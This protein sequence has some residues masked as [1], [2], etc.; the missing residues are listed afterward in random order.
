MFN[1]VLSIFERE[2]I[3]DALNLTW[4]GMLSIFLGIAL[5]F[6]AIFLLSLIKDKK[7]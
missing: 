7:M 6:L 2:S 1:V 3:I 5:I 4:K